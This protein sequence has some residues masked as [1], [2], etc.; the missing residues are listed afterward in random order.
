MADEK[1]TTTR[2]M[3][4]NRLA[5]IK[6]YREGLIGR[7]LFCQFWGLAQMIEGIGGAK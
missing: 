2:T 7:E 5:F 4:E 3:W 6:A 1:E